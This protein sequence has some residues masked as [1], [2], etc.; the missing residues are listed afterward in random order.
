MIPYILMQQNIVDTQ[1]VNVNDL[2]FM[3]H[4]FVQMVGD[5][6]PEK[7]AG[8]VA[9]LLALNLQ[10]QTAP[11]QMVLN[12]F[13]C[14]NRSILMLYDVMRN[15][16]APIHA[17]CAGECGGN[18]LLLLAAAK[19]R[20]GTKNATYFVSQ[21]NHNYA[22]YSSLSDAKAI[23]DSFKKDN[24]AFI[25]LLTSHTSKKIGE[26]LKNKEKYYFDSI[27][28]VKLNVID[29][30]IQFNKEKVALQ[31]QDQTEPATTKSNTAKG[32]KN[33]KSTSQKSSKQESNQSEQVDET[34]QQ[35]KAKPTKKS[36][37]KPVSANSSKRK[38]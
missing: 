32:K 24:A 34:K 23:Q 4:R 2:F 31:K 7:A 18:A 17:T 8:Y 37:K 36:T 13:D 35:P 10:D 6:S 3:K 21:L 29:E 1:P 20:F 33:V 26:H 27:E 38:K 15:I 12:S 25:K 9:M 28:A 19:R 14:D 22:S 30:V 11:I 5:T 16:E